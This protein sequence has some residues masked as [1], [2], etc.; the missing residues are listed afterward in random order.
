MGSGDLV[1]RVFD[2]GG[3]VPP[4]EQFKLPAL[5]LYGDGLLI[6]PGKPVMQRRL[7]VDGMRRVVR[8]A[9]NAGL[10]KEQDFGSPQILDAPVSFFTLVTGERF[11]TTVV[12]PFILDG[13]N[14][15]QSEA[16]RR[17]HTFRKALNDLDSWLGDDISPA[18]VPSPGP[19]V[20]FSYETSGQETIAQ[21]PYDALQAGGCRVL[22]TE[23]VQA[24]G[25]N[26]FWHSGDSVY[27]LVMR[28]L[29]P[30]EQSCADIK[31]IH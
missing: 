1:L 18:T 23:K 26:M 6:L 17:V 28:P 31:P 5:S 4:G 3:L 11:V 9:V 29:L 8:A 15:V 14:A 12:A 16:R 10:T 27:G 21:W 25:Q 30:D 2:T 19:Q 24:L 20:V 13:E 7:T 22:P